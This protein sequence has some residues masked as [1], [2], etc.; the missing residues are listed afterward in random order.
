MSVG[1]CV[2]KYNPIPLERINRTICSIFLWNVGFISSNN[3]CASSKKNTNFGFSRS[4]TSGID[5]NISVN[6]H[7]RN[8]EY[9][10]GAKDSL[11]ES[12][13]FIIPLPL[14]SHCIKSFNSNAGSPKNLFP[15]CSSRVNNERKIVL[16]DFVAIAPYNG[17]YFALF[18]VT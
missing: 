12:N 2:M 7:K 3:R 9:K 1:L 17:S 4:P 11:T 6:I 16:A 14:S 15:P 18:S 5:S 13:T 8:V 10:S